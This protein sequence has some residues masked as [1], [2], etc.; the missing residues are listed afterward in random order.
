MLVFPNAKINLGLNITEKRSDGFH[1]LET[2][3]YPINL[4]DILEFVVSESKTSFINTGLQ[5]NVSDKENLVLRAYHLLKKDIQLPELM[6]HLHKII[7]FGAGLGGGSS[8]AAFMLKALNSYFK[9]N[10]NIEQLKNYAQELGSDCPFF[11]KN[12]PVFAEGTGNIFTRVNSD[13]SD[14]HIL[15]VKP[16]IH[17]STKE[18]FTGIKPATPEFNLRRISDLPISNF[19]NVLINDFEETV[20]RLYPEIKKIKKT[21]Y[22]TGAVYAQMSGS[23]S[24]VFGIYKEKPD[25]PENF[26]SYFTFIHKP[27]KDFSI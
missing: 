6:I 3:F 5:I 16:D 24:A 25:I 8:D 1:N 7:P 12:K 13:L 10:L 11:L 15:I 18:A 27:N 4:C 23:G 14:Y 2:V 22:N 9:L 26:G 20:F 19:K 21:L 17:I